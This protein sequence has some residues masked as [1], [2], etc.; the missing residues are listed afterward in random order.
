M[1]N[2]RNPLFFILVSATWVLVAWEVWKPN[3][4]WQRLNQTQFSPE[5]RWDMAEVALDDLRSG[6]LIL[7]AG[8]TFFSNEL[9]KYNQRDQTFSH[10]GFIT[11]NE[12]GDIEVIHSIGGTDNP[13]SHIK[14][15]PIFKFCHPEE[16]TRFAIY[17]YGLSTKTLWKADSL[18]H[19]LLDKKVPFD[20]KFDLSDD[21]ELYCAEFIYKVLSDATN[22]AKFISL[23]R[24]Q[25]K[26][27]VG[28]DDLF[29][30][31]HCTK[32]FEHAYH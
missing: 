20:L 11:R 8:R 4:E 2:W 5:E 25:D 21:S 30:N 19:D 28:V 22:D 14:R 10:C 7:R 24:F 6:D 17:R 13:D 26:L 31:E 16:V 23:T 15:D 29:L 32:I 9:R 27:Y 3:P 12:E 1:S 18:A